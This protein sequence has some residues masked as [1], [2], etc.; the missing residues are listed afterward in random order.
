MGESISIQAHGTTYRRFS[1]ITLRPHGHHWRGRN[2]HSWPFA[3]LPGSREENSDTSFPV[4]D[5]CPRHP[6]GSPGKKGMKSG[7]GGSEV[8]DIS[9][10]SQ[11]G[12]CV[13]LTHDGFLC[14]RRTYLGHAIPGKQCPLVEWKATLDRVMRS[15]DSCLLPRNTDL[16]GSEETSCRSDRTLEP[17]QPKTIPL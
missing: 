2:T 7:G 10:H 4:R 6:Q 15:T 12:A 13:G 17:A 14:L 11:V 16:V 9:H 5:L 8:A 1:L 3:A